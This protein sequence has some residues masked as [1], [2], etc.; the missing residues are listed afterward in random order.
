MIDLG[1]EMSDEEYFEAT[2]KLAIA[3]ASLGKDYTKV[4]DNLLK[5]VLEL[6]DEVYLDEEAIIEAQ[7]L[8]FDRFFKDQLD[9]YLD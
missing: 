5:F 6:C 4:K 3:L 1:P 7:D 2:N 9:A 8:I